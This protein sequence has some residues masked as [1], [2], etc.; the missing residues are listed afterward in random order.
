VHLIDYDNFLVGNI[1]YDYARLFQCQNIIPFQILKDKYYKNIENNIIY[2]IY[3]LR[4]RL[5][6]YYF[7]K[8]N[9]LKYI[10]FISQCFKQIKK[11]NRVE[12][13]FQ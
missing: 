7:E 11:I 1:L 5:L 4:N 13:T 2:L 8:N 12:K 3:I 10:H 9:N 6:V